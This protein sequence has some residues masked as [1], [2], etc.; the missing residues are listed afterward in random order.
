MKGEVPAQIGIRIGSRTTLDQQ[1]QSVLL[2]RRP[3]NEK[4]SDFIKRVVVEWGGSQL[5]A[6]PGVSLGEKIRQLEG[7]LKIIEEGGRP[8]Q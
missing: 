2:T 4:V 5:D 1:F 7:R 6:F 3:E 8:N